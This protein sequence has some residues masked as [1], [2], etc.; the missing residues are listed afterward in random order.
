[1][2]RFSPAY[3]TEDRSG[4]LIAN[5]I[6]QAMANYQ[7]GKQRQKDEA[8]ADAERQRSQTIQD[9]GLAKEGIHL[10]RPGELP[11]QFDVN[12]SGGPN[13]DDIVSRAI[14]PA[15]VAGDL[16]KPAG[17]SG[18]V[19]DETPLAA[20]LSRNLTM[21][22]GY[23][24]DNTEKA[25]HDKQAADAHMA[26]VIADAL[27]KGR[28]EDM[29]NPGGRQADTAYKRALTQQALAQA[30]AAG[31]RTVTPPHIDPL[32]PAGIAATKSL[33]AYEASLKPD[34]AQD[35]PKPTEFSG[36]AALLYPKAQ[37]AGAVL[38][39]FYDKGV[40]PQ[41]G[42]GR[43]PLVGNF[44]LNE[45]QQRVQQAA[46]AVSSAVLRLESGASISEGEVKNLAKQVIPAP[47]DSPAVLAQ[48]RATLHTMIERMRQA[49]APS[50]AREAAPAGTTAPRVQPQQGRAPA[51]NVD[52]SDKPKG[53][54]I[55]VNGKTFVVPE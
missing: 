11:P 14:M 51:G 8:Q 46:E 52:F 36:K 18:P 7:G 47:G 23:Y 35:V 13:P 32:S 50:M 37:Q 45:D 26:S 34:K 19:F 10:Q 31:Q 33:K 15:L 20:S 22:N 6:T 44:M 42:L 41:Q 9:I 2:G 43:I 55:Q 40:T 17:R 29:L 53:K 49:A 39:Q 21:G 5:A 3:R 28:A 48:K 30:Q 27:G 38:E 54:T 1:M 25:A 24:V 4:D 16:G 12:V